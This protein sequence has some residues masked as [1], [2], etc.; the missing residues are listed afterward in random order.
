MPKIVFHILARE[1]RIMTTKDCIESENIL[2]MIEGQ[3]RKGRAMLHLDRNE[4]M[5]LGLHNLRE[6]V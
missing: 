1:Q 4:M 6:T 2:C 3:K 5:Q